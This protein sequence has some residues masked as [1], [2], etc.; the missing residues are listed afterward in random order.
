MDDD[1]DGTADEE[2]GGQSCVTGELGICAAGTTSCEAGAE[3]C[4]SDLEPQAE[5]C[6]DGL[7]N[8]CDGDTD[9]QDAA[10]C[11]ALSLS[12]SIAAGED[13]AE[14]RISSGGSVSLGARACR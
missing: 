2:F 8:D 14:E 6:D 7:D 9:L 4:E 13:D 3:L 5:I 10:S 1:C 12:V 11:S